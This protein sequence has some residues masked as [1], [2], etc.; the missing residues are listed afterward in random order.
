MSWTIEE[1]DGVGHG[2]LWII[3][4]AGRCI[5][6]VY[7]EIDDPWRVARAIAALPATDAAIRQDQ[8][9]RVA[10]EQPAQD[11]H[12]C[13]GCGHRWSGPP[14]TELCGDCWRKAQPAVHGASQSP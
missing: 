5:C 11:A 6:T 10:L 7:R 2:R 14:G 4:A 3:D 1:R 12:H 13:S 9:Q 8:A